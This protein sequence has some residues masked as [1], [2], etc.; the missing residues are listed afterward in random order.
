MIGHADKFEPNLAVFNDREERSE[1]YIYHTR[2]TL[3]LTTNLGKT[4]FSDR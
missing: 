2:A 4:D 1:L 3:L